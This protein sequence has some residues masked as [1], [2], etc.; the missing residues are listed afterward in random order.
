MMRVLAFLTL[1]LSAFPT[2]ADD[3]DDAV[4]AEMARQGIPG[5]SLAIVDRNSNVRL[6]GYGRA[7]LEHNIAVTPDTVFQMGSIG[8][9]FTAIAIL[10][11]ESEGKLRLT[12]SLSRHLPD[13]PRAWAD[14]KIGHLL[15]HVAGIKDDD[16][17][18]PLQTN[19]TALALRRQI[20]KTPRS[21]R[22]GVEFQYSN[23]AFVL[24]G[25]IIE[26]KTGAPYHQFFD[27]RIFKPLGMTS[28]RAISD[29][30]IIVN[31]ASGY[32]RVNGKL[33]NQEWVS[34]TFNSTADGSSYT[35][36]R[37]FSLW[38]QALNAP[39]EWL[40]P[41][42]ERTLKPT[43]L[44]ENQ[45][46]PYGMGWFLDNLD[47]IAVQSHSGSWQGFKAIIVRYPSTGESFAIFTNA[48]VTQNNVLAVV[49][50]GKAF[51]NMPVPTESS[52][53]E[54]VPAAKWVP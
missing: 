41:F 52:T 42:V 15:S 22:A 34:P 21:A 23:M 35:T 48:D 18:L 2:F 9:Q 36:A 14:I 33:L 43:P 37:D 32:E 29:R 7:S 17:L 19:R 10:M 8:K 4:N 50:A 20:W 13:A 30:E 53:L 51:P 46:L 26:N 16:K 47:G 3:L 31:R 28:T 24:L 27:D 11:L 49:I 54:P 40:A 44:S 39:P 12:D 45:L 1:I 6:A 5:L 38:M 25:H